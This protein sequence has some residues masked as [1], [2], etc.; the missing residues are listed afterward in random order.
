MGPWSARVRARQECCAVS[1]ER[2]SAAATPVSAVARGNPG[3]LRTIRA[4]RSRNYR[5][6]FSGQGVSLIGTWMQSVALGWLVYRL[7]GSAKALGAVA[8]AGQ[9]PMLLLSPFAGVLADRWDLRRTLVATQSLMALQAALLT[10]LTLSAVITQWQ[11]IALSVMAGMLNALDMPARQAFV[12]QMVERPEDLSNAIALNSFLFNG[13]RLVG[14]SLAGLVVAALGEGPC[15]LLNAV[16]FAAVIV[17]LLAMRVAPR[18]RPHRDATLLHGLAEGFAY[19]LRFRP[20]LTVLGLLSLVSLTGMSYATVMPVFA[21]EVL[22]GGPRTY[23]FLLGATGVGAVL[24]VLYLAARPSVLG[25]G[26]IIALGA[27]AFG[28]GL[29]ALAAVRVLWLALPLLL[30]MGLGMMLQIASSNTIIQTIVDEDKRGRVMSIY[31]MSFIGMAPFGS[32]LIGNLA[33]A[34]GVPLTLVLGGGC[35]I[36]G[37]LAFAWQLPTMRRLV[38]PIYVRKGILPE[39]SGAADGH[40]A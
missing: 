1:A 16:S 12:V 22:G 33:D 30:F 39:A 14:P 36:L 21:K 35:C 18:A 27:G 19:V 26:R 4:L 9:I 38:R 25:L 32:L 20:I 34:L 17:A 40:A 8:F 10:V 3:V 24:G 11:I 31:G 28:V 15:F 13:A 5:L 2:V 37:A 7:T 6:F 23:G 29:I